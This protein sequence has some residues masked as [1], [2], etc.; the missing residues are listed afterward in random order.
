VPLLKELGL[1]RQVKTPDEAVAIEP[2]LAQARD[3]IVGATYVASDESGDAHKFTRELARLAVSRGVRF[4][5]GHHIEAIGIQANEVLGVVVKHGDHPDQT[6]TAHAYVVAL[7]SYS[8]LLKGPIGVYLPVYPAKGYSITVDVT[9]PAKAP[10]TSLTDD[11]AKLV[12]SR[13][14][15]RLRVA[16]TAELAGYST[17]VNP[18]RCEAI[19]RR[20]KEFF[21]GAGDFDRATRWAGLRPATP[22][23]VPIVGRTKYANLY[24]NTGHGTLGWTLACGSGAALA[25]IISG[26]KPEVEFK[27]SS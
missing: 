16:G 25:D 7:G 24:L 23:N 10:T 12:I 9:D 17:K 27:W 6:L 3:K 15:D 11:E 19:E 18:V 22:S 13:L 21:P 14:G 4:L 8:P 5:Y 26:R 20:A 2:A 1:E